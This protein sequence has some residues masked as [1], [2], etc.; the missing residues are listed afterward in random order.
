MAI[1]ADQINEAFIADCR[2]LLIT[3]THLSAPTVHAASS[4]ALAYA[5]KHQVLRVLDIDYRPVLWGLTKR[6]EGANRYVADADVTA[7]LQ[8]VLP[9]FDLLIGTE[10]EFLIAGGVAGDLLASLRAVRAVTPAAALVVKLG[11]AGCC[12]IP[13]AIPQRTR[14]RADGPRRAGR[15]HERAGRG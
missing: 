7:Q 6:G 14:G 9:Q 10:E 4:Q 13:G 11:S 5:R 12:F 8:A 15:G 1:D 2:A 3:G